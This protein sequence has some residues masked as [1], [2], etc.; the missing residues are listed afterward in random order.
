MNLDFLE[1]H[2]NFPFD[3][4]VNNIEFGASINFFGKK[5]YP[6]CYLTDLDNKNLPH[7]LDCENIEIG[8]CHFL[9]SFCDFFSFNF[10]GKKFDKL[11]FCNPYGFGL[12]GRGYAKL[13][14]NRAGDIL[15][16]GGTI[17]VF[18]HKTNGWGSYENADRYI[19]QLSADNQLRYT[20]EI[21]SREDISHEHIFRRNIKYTQVSILK[22]TKPNEFFIIK[23]I[24]DV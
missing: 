2:N 19:R 20:L 9:D 24:G 1:K 14:L 5:F 16:D 7:F 3:S 6:K 18:S 21:E 17:H 15:N 10:N 11:I 13:F 23:K 22:E 4:D 12:N 8:H